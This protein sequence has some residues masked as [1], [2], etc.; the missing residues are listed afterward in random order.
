MKWVL[1]REYKK[2]N[3]WLNVEHKFMESFWK[4][5]NPNDMKISRD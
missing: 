5:K 1:V 4:D 2:Y 3:V